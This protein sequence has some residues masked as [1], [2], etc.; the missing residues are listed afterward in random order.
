MSAI[1]D[2]VLILANRRRIAKWPDVQPQS[3]IPLNVYLAHEFLWKTGAE[4]W[5]FRHIFKAL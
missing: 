1:T 5:Q 3:R 2:E 4:L